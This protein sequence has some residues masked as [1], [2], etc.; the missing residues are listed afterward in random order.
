MSKRNEISLLDF[1][2]FFFEKCL[3]AC[4]ICDRT[5]RKCKLLFLIIK[6]K[7]GKENQ[8]YLHLLEELWTPKIILLLFLFVTKAKHII[9]NVQYVQNKDSVHLD[10]NISSFK[11]LSIFNIFISV[12]RLASFLG[13]ILTEWNYK[14]IL[15]RSVCRIG[16][17]TGFW[18]RDFILL[19]LNQRLPFRNCSR[20]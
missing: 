18:D 4:H 20:A 7:R 3:E 5:Q 1:F 8:C 12:S 11:I 2:F 6:S 14:K 16:T 15:Y 9:I 17:S 19:F 13:I 10:H